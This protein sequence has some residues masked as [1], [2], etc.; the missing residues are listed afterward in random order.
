[1]LVACDE[2]DSGPTGRATPVSVCWLINQSRKM[3]IDAYRYIHQ[4]A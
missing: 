1:M 4:K 2:I 3:N